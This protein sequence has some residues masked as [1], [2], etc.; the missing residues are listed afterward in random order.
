ML[1]L[2]DYT[3]AFDHVVDN[4]KA[5]V[6][7]IMSLCK[8]LAR[9][10]PM[11]VQDFF[12]IFGKDNE[13]ELELLLKAK[14][15]SVDYKGDWSK[16]KEVLVYPNAVYNDPLKFRSMFLECLKIAEPKLFN[17]EIRC[18]VC[19]PPSIIDDLTRYTVIIRSQKVIFEFSQDESYIEN[20]YLPNGESI[21][22]AVEHCQK[23]Q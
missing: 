18:E 1:T 4:N 16:N 21:Y 20:I 9:N 10:N 5:Q 15:P 13:A 14:F 6:T 8:I 2:V 17:S 19:L 12:N 11:T 3:F 7:T 22:T 23:K